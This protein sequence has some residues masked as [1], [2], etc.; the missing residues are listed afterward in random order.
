ME[1]QE[2]QCPISYQC[3][4][5]LHDLK[6]YFQVKCIIL[7]AA[8]CNDLVYGYYTGKSPRSEPALRRRKLSG[9]GGRREVYS[10][11]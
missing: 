10:F 6:S 11:V 5:G 9:V 7:V 8:G 3:F 2:V 1:A 4:T